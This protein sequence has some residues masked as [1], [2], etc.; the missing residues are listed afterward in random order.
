MTRPEGTPKSAVPA[1]IDAALERMRE[2]S[3]EVRA[4]PLKQAA[5]DLKQAA[6]DLP[7]NPAV[8]ER[9]G[10]KNRVSAFSISSKDLLARRATGEKA[11]EAP[12]LNFSVFFHDWNAQSKE[13]G[14]LIE[15]IPENPVGARAGL[16]RLLAVG[17]DDRT[18]QSRLNRYAA[19]FL[20]QAR[21]VI[22]AGIELA[23]AFEMLQ[24]AEKLSQRPRRRAAP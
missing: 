1:D 24:G 2:I 22:E 21:P 5:T 23:D 10:D 12:M 6:R 3:A 15:S 4:I 19:D 8:I 17:Y 20:E 11:P 14:A 7:E 16:N 18:A 9:F 13:I